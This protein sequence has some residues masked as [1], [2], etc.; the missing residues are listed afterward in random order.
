MMNILKKLVVYLI[1]TAVVFAIYIAWLMI[2]QAI[3]REWVIDNAVK[4]C[5]E[6]EK[7]G[8][9]NHVVDGAAW[10]NWT[11]AISINSIITEYDGSLL[12]KAV[13]N[14]FTKRIVNS[15]EGYSEL[16]NLK[17]AI[18]DNGE[19]EAYVYSRYW[20]GNM[21]L[22]KIL[23]IFMSIKGIRSILFMSIIVMLS[24]TVINIYKSLG[25]AGVIPFLIAILAGIYIPNSMCL[26]F[27]VDVLI[28]LAL[29]NAC[30]YKEK[31]GG[32]LKPIASY[33]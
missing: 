8:S 25:Y 23:L 7:E 3:P 32:I 6:I 21:T 5:K 29:M 28:M 10:D 2:G 17:A 14:A 31:T 27:G 22:Y 19:G 33:S 11:D 24:I 13:A 26:T 18:D 1:G 30:Y 9:Y 4:S 20:A 12:E 16:N 15:E